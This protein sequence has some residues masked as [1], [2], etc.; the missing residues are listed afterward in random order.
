MP[1]KRKSNSTTVSL[2]GSGNLAQALAPALRS[3]GYRISTIAFRNTASSRRRA[4]ALARRVGAQTIPVDQAGLDADVTWVLH[5][6]D[7]LPETARRLSSNVISRKSAS[8]KSAWKGKIVF[9]SSGALTSDVLAPLRRA[10]AYVASVHPLMTFVPGTQPDFK[11]IPLAVEGDPQALAAAKRIAARLGA[12]VFTI[13]KQ[14]KVLYHALGSFSSPLLMSTL[15]TAER[16]G[17]AAGLSRQ[18]T[19]K[20]IGPIVE[21]T[22]RNYLQNSAADAFSG[23]IKRGDVDTVR[24][25]LRDLRKTPEARQVYRAL[26]KSALREL[27]ARNRRALSTL[28]QKSD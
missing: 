16:V 9:H 23:P 15:A 4:T 24:R 25:H 27:P 8:P 20:M 22:I 12:E 13:K 2:I 10:G 18:Q 5:T 21:Q 3:V 1:G 26:V 17:Q 11:N 19:R 14:S 28:L 6:D 7:A